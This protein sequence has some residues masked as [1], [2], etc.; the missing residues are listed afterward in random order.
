MITTALVGDLFV[1]MDP[2]GD[3]V[4]TVGGQQ[5]L[6]FQQIFS[7]LKAQ[8]G[9]YY[10]TM[11]CYLDTGSGVLY[12]GSAADTIYQDV[13]GIGRWTFDFRSQW[14]TTRL[15]HYSYYSFFDLVT[16]LQEFGHRWG[17][18]AKY[19]TSPNTPG[20]T[21]L[22]QDWIWT[23]GGE[24]AHWGRWFDDGNSSMDYDQ[25]EW[26][27]NGNGT[28]NRIDRDTTQP[29][30]AAWFGYCPLDQYLMGLV[31]DS[32]VAPLKIIQN[33]SPTPTE[34][35]PY[36]VPTGPYTPNPGVATV[37]IAQIQNPKS[38]DPSPVF[39]GP[40]NP[41]YLA[42]QRVF[43]NAIV[44]VTKNTSTSSTFITNSETWRQSHTANVRKVTSGRMMVDT[45][46]LR[47]NFTEI[48]VK[49]NA[50][51]TGA[52]SST[53]PFWET[54]D[55]VTRNAD[56]NVFADQ[57]TIRNQDNWIYVRVRNK[58]AT[59]Y[60]NVTVN[61]YLANF[62][63]TEFLYPVD[64]NPNGIV[65][66]AVIPS[67][68]AASGGNE[69]TAIAKI[70]WP[71][72]KIP[73]AAGWHPCLLVEVIPMEITPTGLHH[74]WENRKLA[75]KNVTIIDPPRKKFGFLVN[76]EF[77]IGHPLR[78]AQGTQLQ[79]D[80]ERH[81]ADV[82]M[83]LDP[84]GLVEDIA[85][86]ATKLA[87]DIPLDPSRIPSGEDGVLEIDAPPAPKVIGYP[88]GMGGGLTIEIDRGTEIGIGGD[89]HGDGLRLRFEDDVRIRIGGSARGALEH[90]H[91][92]RGLRPVV[93]N[94]LPLLEIT[95]PK[96]AS[97]SLPL[98]PGE[99]R[100]LRIFVVVT[101]PLPHPARYQIT[102]R[103]GERV[104]GGVTLQL[105]V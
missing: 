9:D 65:G 43:H 69:G 101:R 16:L 98:P 53:G 22:H 64:W 48:Y 90:R 44:V 61:V 6:N 85:T 18:F 3:L 14:S 71:A 11:S 39:S 51:D 68:P 34:G 4:T 70:L 93:L 104:V 12:L 19:A 38:D 74:V 45:S 32:D 96:Q 99:R 75:Q 100:A 84:A 37:T 47:S 10:D 105:G 77:A 28:W 27:D 30:Q 54:P 1:V 97:L 24:V 102:E 7:L 56:D 26:I 20:Q 72:A 81:A 58:S 55:L 63:G 8:S 46:L 88:H 89:K 79:F 36:N 13:T 103:V 76:F 17:A 40:R 83:F 57:P 21:L 41:D 67:L 52:G 2:N 94:G 23:P 35:G 66:T 87:W 49:D 92:M 95:N 31:P 80:I 50:A 25:A 5:T 91:A 42:S 86:Q 60:A 62:A 59:A 73:P 78:Q 29:A 82:R 15:Q 33:P